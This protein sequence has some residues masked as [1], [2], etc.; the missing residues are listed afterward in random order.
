MKNSSKEWKLAPMSYCSVTGLSITP[1]QSYANNK[2]PA[3][4]KNFTHNKANHS[5]ISRVSF[6]SKKI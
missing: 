1:L 2:T 4:K 3:N 5:N 6:P